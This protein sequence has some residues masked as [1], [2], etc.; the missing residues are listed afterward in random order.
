MCIVK[1]IMFNLDEA[2]VNPTSVMGG[3]I[4]ERVSTFKYLEVLFSE[5]GD[6]DTRQVKAV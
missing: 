3:P 2:S 1:D 4:M 6:W 5:K